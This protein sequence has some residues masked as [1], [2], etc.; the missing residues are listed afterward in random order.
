MK[1]F[2]VIFSV[3]STGDSCVPATN[4][5]LTFETTDCSFPTL[6]W[7]VVQLSPSLNQGEQESTLQALCLN[8]FPT[9]TLLSLSM[10]PFAIRFYATDPVNLWTQNLPMLRVVS[11]NTPTSMPLA[12]HTGPTRAFAWT[13]YGF[14]LDANARSKSSSYAAERK[15]S[16]SDKVIKEKET[17]EASPNNCQDS[18]CHNTIAAPC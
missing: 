12:E 17:T 10:R 2:F 3:Y 1:L 6:N 5:A 8:S 7:I 4:P 11:S 9:R 15:T 13:I 14:Q 18:T 16:S